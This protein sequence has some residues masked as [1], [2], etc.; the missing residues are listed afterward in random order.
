M[1]DYNFYKNKTNYLQ[2]VPNL[3]IKVEVNDTNVLGHFT[4]YK[5]SLISVACDDSGLL[6][7]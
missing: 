5:V 2:T 6:V 3:S 1:F 4:S 7:S